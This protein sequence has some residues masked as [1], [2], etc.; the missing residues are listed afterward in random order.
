MNRERLI[1]IA[2]DLINYI[3]EEL[4][5]EDNTKWFEDMFGITEDELEELGVI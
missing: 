4:V 2:V 5:E 3:S 1:E